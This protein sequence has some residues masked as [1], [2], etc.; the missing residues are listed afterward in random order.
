MNSFR[1]M[2][3]VISAAMSAVQAY[4]PNADKVCTNLRYACKGDMDD[5]AFAYKRCM[6][7]Y[8][9]G[10]ANGHCIEGCMQDSDNTEQDCRIYCEGSNTCKPFPAGCNGSGA[11]CT[12]DPRDLTL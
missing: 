10:H 5:Q 6:C 1:L 11:C 9:A 2:L 8:W 4:S 3:I 7:R 12:F